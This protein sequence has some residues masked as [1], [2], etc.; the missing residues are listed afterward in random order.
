MVLGMVQFTPGF[1]T[2]WIS[3]IVLH[4][5]CHL[6]LTCSIVQLYEALADQ[7]TDIV[8]NSVSVCGLL[9]MLER[10]LFHFPFH[11]STRSMESRIYRAP[12]AS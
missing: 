12:L 4:I 2:A 7:L 1:H 5:I 10:L 8:V 3:G 6:N 11:F 9:R